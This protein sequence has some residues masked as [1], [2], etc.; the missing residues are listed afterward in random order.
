MRDWLARVGG[1]PRLPRWTA[2][3]R[4]L[5][6]AEVF[7]AAARAGAPHC[8]LSFAHAGWPGL[9]KNR[10]IPTIHRYTVV[11]VTLEAVALLSGALIVIPTALTAVAY[12]ERAL[13]LPQLV[14]LNS[15]LGRHFLVASAAHFVAATDG[16]LRV[17]PDRGRWPSLLLEDV[18]PD[19]RAYSTL[20]IDVSNTAT[21]AFSMLVRIDDRRPDPRYEERY[22]Q[23]FELA[24]LSRRVI[25]IPL[26][27]IESAPTAFKMDLAHVQR[28]VLFED[29]SKPTH[30]FYLNSLR[31]ER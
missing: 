4:S 17:Q 12:V 30:G 26:A 1:T 16:S 13:R 19:W 27:D 29:G 11:R 14:Q 5:L 24:P 6:R 23:Q 9:V 10:E 21:Q 20:V 28:I 25:R 15:A 18:W 7:L 3:A 8:A 31:L 22:N 2:K